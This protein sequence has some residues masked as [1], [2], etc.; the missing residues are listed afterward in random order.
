MIVDLPEE[1]SEI[2]VGE[3]S[4]A[5]AVVRSARRLYI[6]AIANGQTTIFALDK[7]GRQIAIIEVSVGR[8][9]AE[10]TEL[11]RAAMPGND[12]QVKTVADSDHPDWARSRR[13]AKPRRRSTSPAA[14]SARRFWAA[15]PTPPP[16]PAGG[17]ARPRPR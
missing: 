16:S 13:P 11:L 6:D 1:A 7:N 14:S 9:V 12:I 10:L 5:N 4:V 15:P 17:P 8:D 3:P 2:F